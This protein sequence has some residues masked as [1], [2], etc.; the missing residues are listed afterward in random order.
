M[1]RSLPSAGIVSLLICASVAGCAVMPPSADIAGARPLSCMPGPPVQIGKIEIDPDDSLRRLLTL[2][3]D[4]ARVCA[5]QGAILVWQITGSAARMYS[6]T[7]TGIQFNNGSPKGTPPEGGRKLYGWIFPAPSQPPEPPPPTSWKYT[8]N[9]REE[10]NGVPD[11]QAQK[12]TCDPTVVSADS[13]EEARAR[14]R[15]GSGSATFTCDPGP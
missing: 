13:F 4:P 15:T 2:D 12:W 14:T 3:H 10:A 5:T 1:T 8:I 6:F 9:F 7:D 11:S